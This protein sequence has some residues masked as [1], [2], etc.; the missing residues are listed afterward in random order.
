MSQDLKAWFR[1]RRLLVR[2][3]GFQG[4]DAT[5]HRQEIDQIASDLETWRRQA[6]K[7]LMPTVAMVAAAAVGH[8]LLTAR[9][10]RTAYFVAY[11][12]GLAGTAIA[13]YGFAFHPHGL[14]P[15][16]RQAE[17]ITLPQ[18]PE[19]ARDVPFYAMS[20]NNAIVRHVT[21]EMEAKWHGVRVE[22]RRQMSLAIGMG[23]LA[24]SFLIQ[25]ALQFFDL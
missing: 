7:Y 11:A 8:F 19:S 17:F 4:M 6:A 12:L 10:I 15:G 22:V 2:V 21:T 25:M 5:F 14:A 24:V 20:L 18:P 3:L 23:F 16:R 1:K 13:A 9:P